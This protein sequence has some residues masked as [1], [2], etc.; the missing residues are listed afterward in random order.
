MS[1]R[2]VYPS[3]CSSFS[4]SGPERAR[5]RTFPSFP[6]NSH[7]S[8]DLGARDALLSFLYVKDRH[9]TRQGERKD[10]TQ[11]FVEVSW[12]L[13]RGSPRGKRTDGLCT[14]LSLCCSWLCTIIFS[15]HE[16][17]CTKPTSSKASALNV[18]DQG[19]AATST[20]TSSRRPR[21]YWKEMKAERSTPPIF[22]LRVGLV[23]S[24]SASFLTA[25]PPAV[26]R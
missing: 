9:R 24:P 8:L 19:H 4:V 3:V 1:F 25:K 16:R 14:S 10:R 15:S 22:P 18:H 21:R 13:S 2:T 23:G 12:L 7:P 20:S 17:T 26:A 5:A 11:A 6:H